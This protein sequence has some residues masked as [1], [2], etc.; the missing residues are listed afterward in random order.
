MTHSARTLHHEL[1][2]HLLSCSLNIFLLI[3][4][5]IFPML[6]SRCQW[7]MY[8]LLSDQLFHL[9]TYL[10]LHFISQNPKLPTV[11]L[12]SLVPEVKFHFIQICP[13]YHKAVPY[14]QASLSHNYDLPTLNTVGV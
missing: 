8:C 5:Y 3:T 12:Y 13:L 6:E 7:Q 11:L 10:T 1:E 9:K 14:F 4:H 2:A